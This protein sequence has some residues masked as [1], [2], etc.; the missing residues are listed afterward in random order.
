[1][2]D[3]KTIDYEN[4]LKVDSLDRKNIISQVNT[5]LENYS[6]KIFEYE[7]KIKK[8]EIMEIKYKNLEREN[9]E[10]SKLYQIR[11]NELKKDNEELEKELFELKKEA[12]NIEKTET[13]LKSI[14][15]LIVKEYGIDKVVQLTDFT[16]KQLEKYI[17]E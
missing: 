5:S 17:G 1:M 11:L 2:E 6:K 16:K 13:G 14:V 10:T 4:N 9:D 3:K 12:L 15:Q 8:Y 7:N